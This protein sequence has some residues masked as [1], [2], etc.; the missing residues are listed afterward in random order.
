LTYQEKGNKSMQSRM[1]V[2]QE[3]RHYIVEDILFGDGQKLQKET[4]FQEHGI[5][6]SVGFLDLIT[7]IEGKYGI[8][9]KD[10]EIVPQN[11]DSLQKITRFVKWK[12]NEKSTP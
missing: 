6:D 4:S 5:I 1:N 9:I 11:F 12:L 2:E 8:S 7:F 3:I 10:D